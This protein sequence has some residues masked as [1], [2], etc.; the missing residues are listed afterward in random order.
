[1]KGVQ[2]IPVL[3][4]HNVAACP[5]GPD[6]WMCVEPVAFAQ[7]M[8]HLADSGYTPVSFDD[9]AAAREQE[10]A[11]PGRPVL[12]TFD[13]GYRG[14][15]ENAMPAL[16]RHGFSATVFLVTD[17]VGTRNTWD[18]LQPGFPAALL[19][20]AQIREMAKHGISFQSHTRSHRPLPSLPQSESRKEVAESREFLQQLLGEGIKYF[21]YPYGLWSRE[22]ADLVREAGYR[23]ACTTIP[24]FCAAA[25]DP[26]SLRRITIRG[27]APLRTF[28]FQLSFGGTLRT[29]T[30]QFLRRHSPASLWKPRDARYTCI[31]C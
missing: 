11:L 16:R 9:W 14:V 28:K 29:L 8:Q 2:R 21:A 20:E 19:S 1:M 10:A 25:D 23:A 6:R 15:Y 12:L 30:G 4:Y 27:D 26:Y 7:Q 17:Y 24:G 22:V 5:A 3:T 31:C 18:R 13:D